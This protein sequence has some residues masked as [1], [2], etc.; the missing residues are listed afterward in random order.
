MQNG[1]PQEMINRA[2]RIGND[3]RALVEKVLN[4]PDVCSRHLKSVWG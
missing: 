4:R 3:V 2:Q 1:T